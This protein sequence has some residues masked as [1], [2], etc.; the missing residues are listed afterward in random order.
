[1]S[2][3]AVVLACALDLLGRSAS[4]LP[5]IRVLDTAPFPVSPNAQAFIN[6]SESVI[7][8]IASAPA[9]RE[10]MVAQARSRGRGQ[11]EPRNALKMIASVIVHEEWHLLN[12]PDE[13]GAYQA[14]LTTLHW[15][16]LGAGSWA[17]SDVTR[18]MH[19]TLSR[20]SR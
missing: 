13:R 17:A 6:R 1:M 9:F 20:A 11:C 8:L 3:A 2:A 19:A 16:G 18:S 4:Q 12:G 14:Q 5:A 10:A 7:Y 15:L